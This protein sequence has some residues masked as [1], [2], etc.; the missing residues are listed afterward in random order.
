MKWYFYPVAGS[1]G[2]EFPVIQDDKKLEVTF[3]IPD[4]AG[5][6]ASMHLILEVT[7]KKSIPFTRYH[8][9]IL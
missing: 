7:G 3:V 6:E 4:I 9:Y 5:N 1:D 2:I 8:R